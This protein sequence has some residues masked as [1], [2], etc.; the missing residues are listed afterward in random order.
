MLLRL[1]SWRR[2]TGTIGLDPGVTQ[3][4]YL[5]AAHLELRLTVGV[6]LDLDHYGITP[7]KRAAYEKHPFF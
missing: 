2:C 1:R 6:L 4:A 7:T 5:A 3:V